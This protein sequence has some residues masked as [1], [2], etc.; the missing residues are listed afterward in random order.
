M[1]K[2]WRVELTYLEKSAR[3]ED[4]LKGRYIRSIRN[5][6]VRAR[7]AQVKPR[8][9]TLKDSM[10]ELMRKRIAEGRYAP[11]CALLRM[12]V[13][14]LDEGRAVVSMD[15]SPEMSNPFGT[16]HGGILCDLADMAM[17]TAFLSTL[18]EG[19]GLATVELKI[20]YLR[21]VGAGK[22]RA[23]AKVTHRGRSTGFIECEV[24]NA[25][26]KLAAKAAS[27]CMIVM[28]ERAAYAA[29]QLKS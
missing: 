16:V 11:V 26:G 9:A 27:T 5:K 2:D 28:D 15:A 4:R 29:R 24:R 17:G 1:E 20:N 12:D 10:L 7:G 19:Q 13:V 22:L 8:G 18:A 6:A 14:E 25:E 3:P 23:E 21:P